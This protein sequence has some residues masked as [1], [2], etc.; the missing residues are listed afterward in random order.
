MDTRLQELTDKIYKE[1]VEK[2]NEEAAK[3]VQDAKDEAAK[4]VAEAQK[5]AEKILADAQKASEELAKNTKSEL[6]ITGKQMVDA[7]KQEIA[8]IVNN[9][10]A[11]S[12]VKPAVADPAFIQ[13]MVKAALGNWAKDDEVKVVISE[14]DEA[15]IEKFITSSLKGM[16]DKGVAIEKVN[17][18]SAGFQVGPADGSYKVSFTDE[19]FVAFFKDYIRPRLAQLLFS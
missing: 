19:D 2:G 11:A 5:E 7:V 4:L 17:G 8:N 16:F 13:T 12:S 18:V 14:K 10:I 15:E 9:E 6:Q 1:G 3:I